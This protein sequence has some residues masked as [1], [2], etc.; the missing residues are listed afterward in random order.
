M[1]LGVFAEASTGAGAAAD[2][3]GT[4]GASAESAV[5][6]GVAA[7]ASTA[8]TANAEYAAGTGAAS[9][10]TVV[11]G[12]PIWTTPA[13]TVFMSSLPEL[14]FVMP[15]LGAA[16]HFNL[17]LDTAASFDTGDF[18]DELSNEDQTGWDYW[19]GSGWAA[20]TGAG[21]PQSFAGN[22]ARYTVQTPLTMTTWFRRVRAGVI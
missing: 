11:S 6:T 21:V 17:Q 9:N 1:A 13:D 22:E 14:K 15:D 2:A 8:I 5:G 4:T 18:R 16:I 12:Q 10:A 20:V 3:T 19:N 7:D